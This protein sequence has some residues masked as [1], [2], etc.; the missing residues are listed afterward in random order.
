[1]PLPEALPPVPQPEALSEGGPLLP[2]GR[3]LA[4]AEGHCEGLRVGALLRLAEP[5]GVE[6]RV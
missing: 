3:A 5:Q 4:L 6:E 2:E 1:M